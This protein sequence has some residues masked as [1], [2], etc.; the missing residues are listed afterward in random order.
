[1]QPTKSHFIHPICTA[2]C[3]SWDT[4]DKYFSLWN[5]AHAAPN[6]QTC[7]ICSFLMFVFKW[8]EHPVGYETQ[9]VSGRTCGCAVPNTPWLSVRIWPVM[10]SSSLLESTGYSTALQLVSRLCIGGDR[11]SS[12]VNF[13][14]SVFWQAGQWMIRLLNRVNSTLQAT[15]RQ[16]STG[17]FVQPS[18]LRNKQRIM[19]QKQWLPCNIRS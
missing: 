8:S 5:R 6:M 16:F 10:F 14:M 1:M 17:S 9:Y 7:W 11:G 13:N 19:W 15:K 18:N 4:F 2:S 12:W 3:S